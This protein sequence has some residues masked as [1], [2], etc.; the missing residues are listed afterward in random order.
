MAKTNR[1]TGLLEAPR[2]AQ[3]PCRTCTGACDGQYPP[4]C[5]AHE[6]K[7]C[8]EYGNHDSAQFVG[9]VKVAQRIYNEDLLF[10]EMAHRER[11]QIDRA[12]SKA[13]VVAK[14]LVD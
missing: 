14:V 2:L 5:R 6:C 11:L 1:R 3:G 12:L 9:L 7:H 13:L 8:E 10:V 4:C